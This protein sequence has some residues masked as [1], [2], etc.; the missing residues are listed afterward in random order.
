LID[1]AHNVA[2]AHALAEYLA[3]SG[4]APLPIVLAVMKDKDAAGIISAVTPV[5]R[6]IV[7]TSVANP[8]ALSADEL[9]EQVKRVAPFVSVDVIADSTA[10][11][12]VALSGSPRAAAAGSIFFVG[13]LRANLLATGAV[14]L[15]S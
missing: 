5:A 6:R 14:S 13:P 11:V 7:A 3:A 15:A 1:A 12:E 2:G 9:G 10:A 8:R 4:A